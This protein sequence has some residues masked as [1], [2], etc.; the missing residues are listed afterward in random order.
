M[1]LPFLEILKL[2]GN[3]ITGELNP[4]SSSILLKEIGLNNNKLND[5]I[6]NWIGDLTNL[7]KLRLANNTLVSSIPTEIG[8]LVNLTQLRL[9]GNKLRG[10]LPTSF[11]SLT[12]LTDLNLS[13][14][15]LFTPNNP[16]R[17][18]VNSKQATWLETQTLAP[19]NVALQVIYADKIL[20]SWEKIDYTNEAGRY[21]ILYCKTNGIYSDSL[22]VPQ[23]DS[24]SVVV[25]KLDND[26]TYYFAIQSF[27][28]THSNN[29]NMVYSS[30][31]TQV[32]GTT[33]KSIFHPKEKP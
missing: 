15:A 10:E 28:D 3:Q 22:F 21:L 9:E 1:N 17:T 24:V 12:A 8:N 23:K 2:D 20:L 16:T 31:S 19:L 30:N 11:T 32:C 18:F 7:E 33:L 27:T 5:T 4:L 29:S 26:S 25:E 6:P 14:N 13:F